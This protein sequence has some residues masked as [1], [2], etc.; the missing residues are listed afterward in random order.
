MAIFSVFIAQFSF[1]F[2]GL[3]AL[4]LQLWGENASRPYIQLFHLM[5]SVGAFITPLFGNKTVTVSKDITL[6]VGFNSDTSYP[7]SRDGGCGR[8]CG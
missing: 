3:Q 8:E 4:L 5:Y 1:L 6:T 7:I 2:S